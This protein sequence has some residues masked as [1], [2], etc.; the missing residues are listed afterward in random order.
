VKEGKVAAK[1]GSFAEMLWPVLRDDVVARVEEKVLNREGDRTGTPRAP[2]LPVGWAY[3]ASRGVYVPPSSVAM[4][5]SEL[6]VRDFRR[7][8]RSTVGHQDRMVGTA[9]HALVERLI[10]D[11]EPSWTAESVRG[12]GRSVAAYLRRSGMP[13]PMVEESVERVLGLATATV[14]G[15]VGRWLLGAGAGGSEQHLAGYVGGRWVAGVLDRTFA[16]S[17]T[18]WVVDYKSGGVGLTG[19]AADRFVTSELARY[20]EG[21][22]RYGELAAHRWPGEHVRTALY[23]PALDRLVELEG[24]TEAA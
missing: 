13:E 4:L 10:A 22:R 7:E 15:K 24:A 1:G 3:P 17:G 5:P 14:E 18:R 6:A 23:F 8:E 12:M 16:E 11:G 21:L 19:A 20:G 9:Y 2:R